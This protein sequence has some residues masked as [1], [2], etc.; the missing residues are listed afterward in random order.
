MSDQPGIY[1]PDEPVIGLE[2]RPDQPGTDAVGIE[3]PAIDA[4]VSAPPYQIGDGDFG[5]ARPTGPYS[6]GYSEDADS[7]EDDAY[8]EDQEYYPRGYY[9]EQPTRQPMFYVVLGLAALIGVGVVAVLFTLVRS[10]DDDDGLAATPLAEFNVQIVSP[11]AGE[12]VNTG[13]SIEFSVQANSNEDI[14]R[15]ELYIDDSVADRVNAVAP[16]SGAIYTTTLKTV[17]DKRGNHSIFVRVYS[18]S[19]ASKDSEKLTLSVVAEAGDNLPT[20][21]GR[22]IATATLR[23]L[24]SEEA[25]AA[26]TL[27]PGETVKIVGKTRDGEWLLLERS[28]GERWVVRTAIQ[29]QDSIALV[30]VREPSP[31]PAPSIAATN[32]PAAETPEPSR[33]PTQPTEKLPDFVPIDARF[34]FTQGGAA[35]LRV[36]IRNDGA[37]YSGPLVLTVTTDPPTGAS[38]S[39]VFNVVVGTGTTTAVDFQAGGNLPDKVNVSVQVDPGNAVNEASEAN[40]T[41][42]FGNVSAPVEPPNVS[43]GQPVIGAN[44]TVVVT[45]SGGPL[46]AGTELVV[47]VKVGEFEKEDRQ[48]LA[49]PLGKGASL[50]FTIAK[51]GSGEGSIA[52]L[53]GGTPTDLADIQIP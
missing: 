15:F 34:V 37:G 36:T 2:Y 26:G 11:R 53:V 49:A 4:G 9:D 48:T 17:F 25:D 42:Q 33:T 46:K 27:E 14:S 5:L 50:T 30:Q 6:D 32:T 45:N 20:V 12:R 24:P 13:K 51:P 3:E 31:T 22:V 8:E 44:I 1:P 43:L 29:E 21:E 39:V 18:V 41:A 52:L 35:A 7:Y 19:G 23:L 40:N 10:G 47:R 16:T 28:N 38:G